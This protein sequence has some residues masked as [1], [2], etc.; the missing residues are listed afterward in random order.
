[1]WRVIGLWRRDGSTPL[2]AK[3]KGMVG[4][5]TSHSLSVIFSSSVPLSSLSRLSLFKKTQIMPMWAAI[6]TR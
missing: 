3:S 5:E 2:A 1:M 6:E 4:K